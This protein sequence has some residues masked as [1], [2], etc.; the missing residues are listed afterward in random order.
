MISSRRLIFSPVAVADLD[1]IADYIARDNPIRA[2]SFVAE[3]ETRCRG[4]A[5]APELY[6]LRPDLALGIRM[7]AHGRYLLLYRDLMAENIVRIERVLHSARNIP[8]LL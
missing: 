5:E 1:E 8:R 4:I 6:P 3:L 7:A 2:V